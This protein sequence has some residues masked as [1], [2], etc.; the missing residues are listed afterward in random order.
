M[1][2]PLVKWLGGKRQLLDSLLIKIPKYDCYFEPFFGGGALFFSINPARAVINDQNDQLMNLYRQIKDAPESV[3]KLTESLQDRYNRESTDENRTRTYYAVREEFNQHI[4]NKD[5]SADAA[6]H[7]LF[8]NKAGFNGIYRVNSQGRYNVPSAHKKTI[9]AFETENVMAVSN[10]L[11]KCEIMHGDFESACS[12]AK[13]GDFVFFDSPYYET[14]DSYRAGGF[15]TEDHKRLF[16]LFE[17]LTKQNICCLLTNSNTDFIKDMYKSYRID[18]ID[19]K[20]LVNRDGSN[21]TGSEVI[22]TNS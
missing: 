2:T 13:A 10:A 11:K 9:S 8:L 3:M 22:I 21:R 1:S 14:F 15:N 4:V 16:K 5:Y 19:V 6:A 18:T 20:R 12:K 7:L 17:S